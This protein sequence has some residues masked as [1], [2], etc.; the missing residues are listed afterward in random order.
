MKGIKLG[1]KVYLEGPFQNGEMTTLLNNLNL[2]PLSQPYAGAPWNYNGLESV[3]EIPDNVVDWVLVD[4]REST[5]DASTATSDKTIAKKAAFLMKDGL[6]KDINGDQKLDFAIFIHHNLYVV[7]YH[8][9]HISVISSVSTSNYKRE[10]AFI[11]FHQ[12]RVR[13]WVVTSDIKKLAP[14]FGV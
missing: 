8:R 12:E 4:L 6:V 2:I 3:T 11:I 10:L 7:I 13:L 9:N 5:G 14:E 1:L